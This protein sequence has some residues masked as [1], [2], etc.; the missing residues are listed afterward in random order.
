MS[1][2]AKSTRISLCERAVVDSCNS[3]PMLGLKGVIV[4][5]DFFQLGPQCD[6][7]SFHPGDLCA[8]PSFGISPWIEKVLW[9]T[10]THQLLGR[11]LA[12]THVTLLNFDCFQLLCGVLS[13]M[14]ELVDRLFCVLLAFAQR[15]LL[16]GKLRTAK[17]SVINAFRGFHTC[18]SYLLFELLDERFVLSHF[19]LPCFRCQR[20][21]D[22]R[23]FV[24]LSLHSQRAVLLR[25]DFCSLQLQCKLI[26]SVLH[27][28]R[29]RQLDKLNLSSKKTRVREH[30]SSHT[31]SADC[32]FSHVVRS[33]RILHAQHSSA[34]T[35]SHRSSLRQHPLC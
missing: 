33:S 21:L 13:L 17:A 34:K 35:P 32:S 4:A 8:C 10:I 16:P 11:F 26:D 28:H 30:H 23:F 31:L 19:L 18:R 2:S 24:L 25:G 29:L 6:A 9:T 7:L 1:L 5:L 14:L 22:D 27:Q 12:R 20:A 15:L 3:I